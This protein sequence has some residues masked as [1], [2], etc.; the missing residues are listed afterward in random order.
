MIIGL[1]LINKN[2]IPGLWSN[3]ENTVMVCFKSKINPICPFLFLNYFL[4]TAQSH[5]GTEK[6]SRRDILLNLIVFLSFHKNIHS[7]QYRF[8]K[9]NPS[10]L[11]PCNPWRT[12]PYL[13]CAPLKAVNCSFNSSW[14]L[15]S[16]T[17]MIRQ[18]HIVSM[19]INSR[20][21]ECIV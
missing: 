11:L 18:T 4:V 8:F 2:S 7:K 17:N 3:K 20:I 6:A 1:Y 13:G 12:L 16:I 10:V 19:I 21:C 14:V 15:M 5:S 9:K